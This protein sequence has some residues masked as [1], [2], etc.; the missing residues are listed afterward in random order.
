MKKT[1]LTIF[2]LSSM[3]YV[4]SQTG[5]DWGMPYNTEQKA[6][7]IEEVVPIDGVNKAELYKRAN[8][9]ITEYFTSGQK[10]IYERDPD[11]NFLK[12]KHR[13]QLYRTVKKERVSDGLV[14]FHL[15]IYLKDGKFKYIFNNFRSVADA[16]SQPIEKWMD[17]NFTPKE[18]A[19]AKYTNLNTMMQETIDSMK[20]YMQTGKKAANTDF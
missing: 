12:L 3:M 5:N 18:V 15:E 6:F 13:I 7:M 11:Q 2:A 19:V 14:E 4:F 20:K 8:D 9:W 17:P 16:N 10:K 1:I